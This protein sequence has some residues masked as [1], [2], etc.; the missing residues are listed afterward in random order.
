MASIDTT[1]EV[2]AHRVSVRW[3]DGPFEDMTDRLMEHAEERTKE[4]IT[5]GYYSGELCFEDESRSFRGWWEI[6]R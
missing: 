2:C 3:W 4:M 6:Q 5:Q 1:I